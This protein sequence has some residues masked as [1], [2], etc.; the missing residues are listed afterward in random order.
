MSAGYTIGVVLL[1]VGGLALLGGLGWAANG[2]MSQEDNN[3]DDSVFTEPDNSQ[4]RDQM[5][6][7]FGI[8]GLGLLF[9]II[10]GVLMGT[11]RRP[12]AA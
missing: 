12:I 9:A 4:E 11:S 2:Y 8:A 6:L 5:N 7:G 10:G 1:V 3:Q